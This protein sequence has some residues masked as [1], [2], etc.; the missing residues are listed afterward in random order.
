MLERVFKSTL[1]DRPLSESAPLPATTTGRVP[2]G[3][4]WR[5]AVAT[6]MICMRVEIQK[7]NLPERYE[8]C[9]TPGDRCPPT[10]LKN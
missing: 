7:R 1:K 5:P 4:S 3:G 10:E 9:P 6:G 2:P 8:W